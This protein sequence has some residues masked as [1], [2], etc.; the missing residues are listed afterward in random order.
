MNCHQVQDLLPAYAVSA[1]E[2]NMW[3]AVD[4]HLQRCARCAYQAQ[5]FLEGAAWLSTT[6]GHHP[7]PADLKGRVLE[8]VLGTPVPRAERQVLSLDG[9]MGWVLVGAIAVA[10]AVLVGAWAWSLVRHMHL[11]RALA[12]QQAQVERLLQALHTTEARQDDRLGHLASVLMA[13]QAKEDYR[14]ESLSRSLHDL[15]QL[16]YWSAAP[17]MRVVW[18]RGTSSAPTAYGM[19][20]APPEWGVA[21]LVVIGLDPLPPAQVYQVWL[22]RGDMRIDGGTFTVDESGWA[23]LL[24]RPREPLTTFDG[25]RVTIEPVQGSV[26]PSGPLVLAAEL[27]R[28]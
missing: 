10:V 27:L 1:L 11:E 14:T 18:V 15:R 25:L 26:S 3:R 2:P 7:L 23:Q 5:P 22:T 20:M 13:M 4:S 6:A 12:R 8:R 16:A 28:R 21:I 17:D 9:H 24:V 19:L